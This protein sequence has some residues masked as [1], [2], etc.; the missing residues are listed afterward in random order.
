MDRRTRPIVARRSI[1]CALVLALC[2][3]GCGGNS[4]VAASSGGS[5]A[6]VPSNSV[7]VSVQNGSSASAYFMLA[8]MFLI[9]NAY[10]QP[11]QARGLYGANPGPIPPMDESRSVNTQDC[12]KAIE[13][14]SANLRCK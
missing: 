13:N 7:S 1:A 2:A 6:A 4:Y 10:Q 3:A 12:S 5:P 14:W 8:M 9:G 11:N